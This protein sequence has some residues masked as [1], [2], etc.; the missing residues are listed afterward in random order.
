MGARSSGVPGRAFEGGF[1][2]IPAAKQHRA[3]CGLPV[4]MLMLL[5]P[6]LLA[7]VSLQGR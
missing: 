1:G 7:G 3:A 2:Q 4:L 6:P 5:L